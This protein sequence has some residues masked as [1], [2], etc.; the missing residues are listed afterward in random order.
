MFHYKRQYT[1]RLLGER[2]VKFLSLSFILLELCIAFFALSFIQFEFPGNKTL[3]LL[4]LGSYGLLTI[5]NL[6]MSINT[7]KK[8]LHAPIFNGLNFI[9]LGATCFVAA[10]LNLY[11]YH[12]LL[13]AVSILIFIM[14]VI[15]IG[16]FLRLIK[17][18]NFKSK[19]SFAAGFL[20]ILIGRLIYSIAKNY[21]DNDS[22]KIFFV[23]CL[24]LLA[25]I[26]GFFGVFSINKTIIIKSK[27][28]VQIKYDK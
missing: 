5:G 7:Y 4:F 13:V 8:L 12:I 27:F 3:Y 16:L 10:A 14:A 22:N 21:L 26:F 1:I 25:F 20:G 28:N 23:V 2:R 17:Y 18:F 9:V 11:P 19:G 6:Y 24:G 15:L